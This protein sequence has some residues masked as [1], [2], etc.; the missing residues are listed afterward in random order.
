MNIVWFKRDLRIYDNQALTNA[1]K[2]SDEILPLYIIEP[3]L[4]QQPDLSN[5]QYLFL[6]ECLEELNTELTKLGQNLI[7]TV[8]D[9]CEVFAEL[10]SNYD[11]QSIY[12]HQE[13]WNLWTFI[14]DKK[15][16]QL[17]TDNQIPWLE[18][19]QNGV[20]RRLKDRYGWAKS[21][22]SFMDSKILPAPSSLKNLD[23][24]NHIPSDEIA[25]TESLNL[26]YDDCYKRQKGGRAR[27]LRILNTFLNDRGTNYSKEMSSPVT[28]FTSCS[29]LSPYIAFGCIS[30]RE[31]FQIQKSQQSKVKLLTNGTKTKHLRSI[32][33][34]ASRLRWHCH[35]MQ[36][37]EDEVS[38]E[39]SNLHPAYNGL[40]QDCDTNRF[41]AWKTGCTGYPL[42]DACMRALIA[43]GWL[44][45]R[46]RAMLMSFA[47]YHLWLNWQK[48]AEYL[49]TLFTDYEPGIHYSQVQ[50]QSGTT[51][52][53]SIRIYNPIKQSLDQDPEG[54]FIKRWIPELENMPIEYIH[55]PWQHPE[56]LNEYPLPIVEESQARKDAAAKIYGVRKNLLFRDES[57]KI[58]KKH[59]SRK[60]PI[61]RKTAKK[62]DST[63]GQLF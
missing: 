57:T 10:I 47:S 60:K 23:K 43:T 39:H 44:N 54:V 27:A 17:L 55:T 22:Y 59:A 19:I 7:I 9:A 37:L 1:L 3:E 12:S 11:I 24:I 18:P 33:S 26:D 8:G 50:M 38:I 63:Q 48:T 42:I 46:M 25:T 58:L 36:K 49:A 30:M 28:A 4:W 62:I 21:W 31:V 6:C 40:R 52:I 34:F 53:N 29:R 20:V 35:F 56:L 5:R 45:F 15:V 41:N 2:T 16:K 13:T 14:R 51:G 61:K 32:K